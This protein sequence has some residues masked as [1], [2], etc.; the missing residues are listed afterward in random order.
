VCAAITDAS[1]HE[2]PW[3]TLRD[4]ARDLARHLAPGGIPILSGRSDGAR[5]PSD[6]RFAARARTPRDGIHIPRSLHES[7][8][9]MAAA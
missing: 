7:I 3:G 9:D 4:M 1:S 6:R 5:L 8:T 2:R